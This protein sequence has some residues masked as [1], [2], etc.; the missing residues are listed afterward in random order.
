MAL[1]NRLHRDCTR[2][3]S[4]DLSPMID[5]VFILLI[6]F[7]VTTVFVEEV[8]IPTNGPGTVNPPIEG[9]LLPVEIEITANGVVKYNERSIGMN[10]VPVLIKQL[11]SNDPGVPILIRAHDKA[12]HQV[13]AELYGR[14]KQAGAQKISFI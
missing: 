11:V 10:G 3:T 1:T 14:V 5:C 13:F 9:S 7:I 2:N 4:I 8:G 6:F 12:S